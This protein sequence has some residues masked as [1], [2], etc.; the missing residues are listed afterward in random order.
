[1]SATR[2]QALAAYRSLL[3]AQKKTF[4]DSQ[5]LR[6]APFASSETGRFPRGSKLLAFHSARSKTYTEFSAKRDETDEKKI[7]EQIELANQVASLLRHNLAQA[8]RVD[9]QKEIYSLRLDSEHELGDNETLRQASKL[10]RLKNAQAAGHKHT[11]G[12][13]S[14]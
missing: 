7:N 12:C 4:T 1:M 3:K 5:V 9:D 2:P 10:R 6:S 13:C 14:A 11:G 8:V